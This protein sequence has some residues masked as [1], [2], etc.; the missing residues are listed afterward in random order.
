MFLAA[1][2]IGS[3]FGSGIGQQAKSHLSCTV[4]MDRGI[5][6]GPTNHGIS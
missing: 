2:G 4:S 5:Q 6:C 1:S 3:S